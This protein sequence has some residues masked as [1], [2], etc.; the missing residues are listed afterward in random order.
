[1]SI[2][3]VVAVVLAVAT[4][5]FIIYPLFKQRPSQ[6]GLAQDDKLLE[7]SSRRDTTYSMLKELE[8]DFQSGILTEEDY[9][10][11]ETRYKKKAI[12]A[13]RGID[14][15]Q[16]GTNVEDEIEKRVLQLRQT[17]GRFCPQCGTKYQAGDRLCASCGT[18]LSQGENVD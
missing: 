10:D 8:F 13:L 5:V 12:S 9:R 17:K 4:F 16:E 11:L 7:L 3:D 18:D 14:E 2:F 6:E 15:L 1:M